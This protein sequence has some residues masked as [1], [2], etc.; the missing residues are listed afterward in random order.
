MQASSLI[1][2]V[3]FALPHCWDLRNIIIY[4]RLTS[5]IVPV[6]ETMM[7]I[8]NVKAD[9]HTVA[10]YISLPLDGK[11]GLCVGAAPEKGVEGVGKSISIYRK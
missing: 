4:I 2:V 7:P 8:S 1:T 11:N 6:L 9:N 10:L 5:D 3:T